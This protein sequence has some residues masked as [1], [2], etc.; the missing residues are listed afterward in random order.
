MIPEK[1]AEK[2]T[3]LS[4]EEVNLYNLRVIGSGAHIVSQDDR[5]SCY[6]PEKISFPA[7]EDETVIFMDDGKIYSEKWVEEGWDD[8]KDCATENYDFYYKVIVRDHGGNII[9]EERGSIYQAADGTWWI[10]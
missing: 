3:E 5:F 7:A 9:S 4:T 10:A 1:D 6:Y 2:V 8:E